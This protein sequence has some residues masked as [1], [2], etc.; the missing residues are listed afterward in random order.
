MKIITEKDFMAPKFINN[1]INWAEYC[2]YSAFPNPAE[3]NNPA[4]SEFSEDYKF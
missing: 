4:F 2:D 3:I 1:K